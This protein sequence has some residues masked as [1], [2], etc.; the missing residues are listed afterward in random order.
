MYKFKTNDIVYIKYYLPF[1]YELGMIIEFDNAKNMY[2]M[3]HFLDNCDPKSF[4]KWCYVKEEDIEFA[5]KII[6]VNLYQNIFDKNVKLTKNNYL[7]LYTEEYELAKQ[8][9][10]NKIT[11]DDYYTKIQSLYSFEND[12]YK[13]K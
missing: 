4:W 7:E 3:I 2:K 13:N 8:V 12:S 11:K 6:D 9:Y 5:R 1:D 10:E